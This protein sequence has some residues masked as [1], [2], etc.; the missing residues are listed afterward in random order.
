MNEQAS[1]RLHEGDFFERVM[2]ETTMMCVW[3]Q[4]VR[5][6][7]ERWD[8]PAAVVVAVRVGVQ[9]ARLSVGPGRHV[10]HQPEPELVP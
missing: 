1:T 9:Y 7:R 5:V 3:S 10:I 4:C 2:C 6:R 8:G